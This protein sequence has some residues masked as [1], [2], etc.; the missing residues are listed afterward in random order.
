MKTLLLEDKLF[1]LLPNCPLAAGDE[2]APGEDMDFIIDLSSTTE[3][4]NRYNG[5]DT[6]FGSTK[7]VVLIDNCPYVIKI[8]FAGL[9]DYDVDE[10]GHYFNKFEGALWTSEGNSWNYCEQEAEI[11]QR[12]KEE[13]VDR[14]FAATGLWKY[15]EEGYPLYWQV[16]VKSRT[17][18]EPT[19]NSKEVIE[20]YR[21]REITAIED[22]EWAALFIDYYGSVNFDRLLKFL[23]DWDINDLRSCNLGYRLTGEPVILDYSGFHD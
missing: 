8:P 9:S 15:T 18:E 21:D 1:N 2:L 23:D 17:T 22:E 20:A 4:I 19:E 10:G 11:Y 6:D 14:F 7:F 16:R 3:L 13:K 12:A 5:Y